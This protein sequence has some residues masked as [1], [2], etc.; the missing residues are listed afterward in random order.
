MAVRG[1]VDPVRGVGTAERCAGSGDAVADRGAGESRGVL[2]DYPAV[3]ADPRASALNEPGQRGLHD[4]EDR[5]N[6]PDPLARQWSGRKGIRVNA[7][8]PGFFPSEMTDS[9]PDELVGHRLVMGRFGDPAELAAAM[10]FLASDASGYMTGSE[11]V[12]DGGF[13]LS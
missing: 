11:L 3:L 2:Q 1:G 5:P 6:R 8:L 13:L 7:L 12:V 4:F 9:M 10:V